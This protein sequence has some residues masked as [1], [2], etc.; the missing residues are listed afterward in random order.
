MN[1]KA[2][3]VTEMS[4]QERGKLEQQLAEYAEYYQN[5]IKTIFSFEDW[6]SHTQSESSPVKWRTFKPNNLV[7]LEG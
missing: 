2:I 1:V 5:A 6:L 3:D 4:E 7:V